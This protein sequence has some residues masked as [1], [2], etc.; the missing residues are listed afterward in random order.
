VSYFLVFLFSFSVY[1]STICRYTYTVWNAQKRFS[2]GPFT[3][4]K[5]K[6]TLTQTEKGEYGCSVC[7]SDQED[8]RLSNGVQFR[9]CKTMA[10]KFRAALEKILKSGKE[11]KT[12]VG[13]RPSISKGSLDSHGRRTE[14]SRHA[15]G[16]AIDVNENFNGLYDQC[17]KWGPSCRLIKGGKYSPS[18]ALSITQN[19]AEVRH[20]REEGLRWGGEI[21]GFQKDFMHF[22]PDGL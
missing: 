20:F 5:I 2:E 6:T 14:F 4:Q 9:A 7:E 11:I 13:Y 21:E 12:V 3:V 19:S 10:M 15:F 18:Q 22:S 1:S 8:I 17:I 16:I